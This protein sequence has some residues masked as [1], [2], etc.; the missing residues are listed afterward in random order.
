MSRTSGP[1]VGDIIGKSYSLPSSKSFAVFED[2]TILIFFLFRHQSGDALFFYY[3]EGPIKP[4][5]YLFLLLFRFAPK[6][7]SY[8]KR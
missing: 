6:Q 5:H 1:A 3:A 8:Q 7:A 2:L 4:E